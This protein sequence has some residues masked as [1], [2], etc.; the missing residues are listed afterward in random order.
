MVVMI[1]TAYVVMVAEGLYKKA[2]VYNTRS[3]VLYKVLDHVFIECGFDFL[4]LRV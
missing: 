4:C 1:F 2:S 3:A